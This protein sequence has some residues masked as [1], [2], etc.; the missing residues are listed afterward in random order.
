MNRNIILENLAKM[1]LN[2]YVKWFIKKR[3]QQCYNNIIL[4][5]LDT[6]LVKI[7]PIAICLVIPRVKIRSTV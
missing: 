3:I 2:S 1:L 4:L 5:K 7:I 6:V